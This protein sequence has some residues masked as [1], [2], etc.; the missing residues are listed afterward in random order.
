LAV[1]P[2]SIAVKPVGVDRRRALEE[3]DH[4]ILSAL[5][6]NGRAAWTEIANQTGLTVPT[7]ARRAKALFK[8][9]VLKVSVVSTLGFSPVPADL[10]DVQLKCKPGTQRAVAQTMAARDDTRW[11]AVVTGDHDV[12]AELVVP[13]GRDVSQFLIDDI[14]LAPDVVSA[15][16]DL[17]VHTFKMAETW[18]RDTGD[19]DEK[20]LHVCDES[21]LSSADRAI[22]EALSRDGR[23][24]CASVAAEIGLDESTVGRRLTAMI[25]RG[26]ARVVTIVQPSSLGYEHGIVLRLEVLPQHLEAAAKEVMRDPGVRYV[27]A[28]FARRSLVCEVILPH[29]AALYDFLRGPVAKMPG[30][31]GM[32]AEIELLVVKRAFS[33]CPWTEWVHQ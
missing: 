21:H 9:N 20:S 26:C 14:H 25:R 7:V 12:C 24:S 10:Y 30:V 6:C 8:K 23:R 3:I 18:N 16:A 29:G 13:P 32:T 17:V 28:M 33:L 22:L 1:G 31:T 4:R 19:G 15:H 11:V 2:R 27:A 5:Q